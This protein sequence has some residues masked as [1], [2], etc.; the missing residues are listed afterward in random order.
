MK[1]RCLSLNIVA[2]AL[3]FSSVCVFAE[4]QVTFEVLAT[5]DYPG[6]GESYAYKINDDGYVAGTV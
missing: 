1:A 3:A 2:T 4:S 5:F 6:F